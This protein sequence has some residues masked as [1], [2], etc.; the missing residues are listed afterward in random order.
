[1]A[2]INSI[3]ILFTAT[4]LATLDT[5]RM[6]QKGNRPRSDD[7][8]QLYNGMGSP[9]YAA[10]GSIKYVTAKPPFDIKT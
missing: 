2:A 5:D 8:E 1:M 3:H 10:I 9:P 6:E 4:T 7:G